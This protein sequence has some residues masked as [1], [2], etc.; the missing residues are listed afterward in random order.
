MSRPP[1]LAP[2]SLSKLESGVTPV[3]LSDHV[4]VL[5]WTHRTPAIVSVLLRTRRP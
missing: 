4:I 5:G 3:V 1:R 2:E